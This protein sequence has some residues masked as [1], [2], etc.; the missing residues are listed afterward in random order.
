MQAVA[1]DNGQVLVFDMTGLA[2]RTSGTLPAAGS[3]YVRHIG[4]GPCRMLL[5]WTVA[6][7]LV[8]GVGSGELVMLNA[9]LV[10]PGSTGSGRAGPTEVRV[11][12]TECM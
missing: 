8:A 10:A 4:K 11:F 9:I 1:G 2:N 7:Q 6:G 12:H 3:Y 5:D